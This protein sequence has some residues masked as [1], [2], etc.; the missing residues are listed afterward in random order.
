MPGRR[1]AEEQSREH[2]NTERKGK[3]HGIEPDFIYSRR[4]RGNKQTQGTNAPI[5]KEQPEQ[6]PGERQEQALGQQLPREP[7]APGSERCPDGELLLA[8]DRG[9]SGTLSRATAAW[10]RLRM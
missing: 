2:G 1:K 4:L 7:G 10:V 3:H 6:A 8:S 5:G 9:V